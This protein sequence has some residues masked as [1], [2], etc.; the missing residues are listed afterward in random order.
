MGR[1]SRIGHADS[2][3]GEAVDYGKSINLLRQR[4]GMPG[5]AVQSDPT[6]TRFAD[7]GHPLSD[8]LME[9]RRERAVELG[10]E[11]FRYDDIRRW[12]A[13]KLLKGK[14]RK[15]YPFAAADWTG[16]TIN[17]QTD[18]DGFLDPFAGQMPNGYGFDENRD[19][20]ECIPTNEITMNPNLQQNPGWE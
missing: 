15:G 16:T 17:Y 11:G 1:H 4:A 8:E 9:I 20:L 5:F 14:R 18:G 3:L 2:E 7:Y 19:Y 12:T 13:H 6:R 10:A